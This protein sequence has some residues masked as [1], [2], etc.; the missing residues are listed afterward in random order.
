MKKG[1]ILSG[2]FLFLIMIII[3]NSFL[4]SALTYEE[5]REIAINAYSCLVDKISSKSCSSLSSAEKIVSSMILP[6][7]R[8]EVDNKPI[9]FTYPNC[10]LKEVSQMILAKEDC[11]DIETAKNWILDQKRTTRDLI[12]F[13]EIDSAVATNCEISYRGNTYSISIGED[14]KVFGNSGI[15]LDSTSTGGYWYEIDSSCYE[16]EF[17]IKC[18]QDFL[19]TLLFKKSD[20]SPTYYVL[21]Y[22]NSG[23]A[24]ATLTEKIESYCLGTLSDC[25]YEG[26]LWGSLILHQLGEDVQAFLPYLIEGAETSENRK[27][28]PSSFLYSITGEQEYRTSLLTKFVNGYW[29][30]STNK[31]YDSSLAMLALNH[32][33]PAEEITLKESLAQNQETSGCWNTGNFYDTSWILYSIWPQFSPENKCG[34]GG[35]ECTNAGDCEI[36][37]CA[38]GTI[39]GEECLGGKCVL[40]ENCGKECQTISDCTGPPRVCADGTI[41]NQECIDGNCVFNGIC[42]EDVKCNLDSECETYY[43]EDGK[44]LNEECINQQCR[45]TDNCGENYFCENEGDCSGI[46][47]CDDGTKL[48]DVCVQGVCVYR[49]VCV[50]EPECGVDS[51]CPIRYCEDGSPLQES[52]I[53]EKCILTESCPP[54]NLTCQNEG[55]CTG[56]R[57]CDDGT[58]LYDSCIDGFCVFLENCG[59]EIL[60]DSNSDCSTYSCDDWSTISEECINGLCELNEECPNSISCSGNSDCTN[61]VECSNGEVIYQECIDGRCL[62]NFNKRCDWNGNITDDEDCVEAGFSCT[63]YSECGL[64]NRLEEYFCPGS[65]ICCKE[66]PI[67]KTCALLGGVVCDTNRDEYCSTTYE[68]TFGLASYEVCCLNNGKCLVKADGCDS[69]SDCYSDQECING[70]CIEKTPIT[71]PSCESAGGECQSSGCDGGYTFNGDYDCEE[72]YDLCC[73]PDENKLGWWIWLLF[74][75]IVLSVIAVVFRE[76]LKELILRIKTKFSKKKRP[77]S[78]MGRPMPLMDPRVR[79]HPPYPRAPIRRPVERKIIPPQH[80]ERPT[81]RPPLEI[82]KREEPSPPTQPKKITSPEKKPNEKSKQELDEVLKKLKDMG[83]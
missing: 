77:S 40:N 33:N 27:Y 53:N 54:G 79:M 26:T 52:C 3:G 46:K 35:G 14:K 62:Y 57:T 81:P 80:I 11:S 39:I 75:L 48:Y 5:E 76:Q 1:V 31:L 74:G 66:S 71:K 20:G 12:W 67:R 16:E 21:D 25:D 24:D 73:F 47:T 32:E 78:G 64:N 41:L 6:D 8:V 37:S 7:C 17:S 18:N 55:D 50:N 72:S 82:K 38:D 49:E 43:C 45:L 29:E 83:K 61:F 69:N 56:E 4:I 15:C 70:K 28:L 23:N 44:I 65:S 63:L 9:C 60:C 42:D 13:L 30:V 58:K 10:N 22:S 36:Y 34:S 51:D 19:T 59:N 68:K 2:I